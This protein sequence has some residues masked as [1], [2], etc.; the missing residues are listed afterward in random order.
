MIWIRRV[1]CVV[2]IAL[3]SIAFAT[4]KRFREVGPLLLTGRQDEARPRLEQLRDEFAA[5]GNKGDEAAAWLLLGMSDSSG[6]NI[7]RGL[8]ELRTA[9]GQFTASGD[10]LGA[11]LCFFAIASLEHREALIDAAA[12]DFERVFEEIRA[13]RLPDAPFSLATLMTMGEA[14]GADTEMV[15]PMAMQP[16]MLKPIVLQLVESASHDSFAALLLDTGDFDRAE[17]ELKQ[18][19]D[20]AALFGGMLDGS[21]NLHYAQLRQMQWRL[22][23][24]RDYYMKS[25]QN[26]QNVSPMFMPPAVANDP[27]IELDVLN[28][29]AELELLRGRVDEAL[30]WNDRGL[31]SAR[32]RNDTKR[33]TQTMRARSC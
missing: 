22:D 28:N 1:V 9:A 15:G 25:L 16:A 26:A 5:A 33:Q 13:A 21:L 19:A 31:L 30:A 12:A 7:T 8:S 23:E 3:P 18:A 24:A 14:F 32:E 6:A 10:H 20:M 17:A 29:L 4:D 11:W 27:W 2:L